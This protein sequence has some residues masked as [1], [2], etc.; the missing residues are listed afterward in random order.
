[1]M[2]FMKHNAGDND[3][4]Q[5]MNRLSEYGIHAE[6]YPTSPFKTIFFRD[7]GKQIPSLTAVPGVE[8]IVHTE[9]RYRLTSR[10]SKKTDTVITVGD[11][12]IGGGN[13]CV[14]AGPCAVE[15]EQL[16]LEISKLLISEGFAIMRGGAFKPRTSPYS[17][18]GLGYDGLDILES[19]KKE[20]GILVVTEAIDVESVDRVE[21]VADIIQVGSRNM[22]NFSLLKH[23]GT[24]SRPVLLKRGM[25]STIEEL[26][27][28]AEYIYSGGNSEIIL[29]ERGIRTF[30]TTTRNTLDLT[31]I[32]AIK[33]LSHLP[34]MVDPS[35]AT[36]RRNFIE[37]ISKAI[38]AA[39]ADGMLLEVHPN[40]EF[41]LSD[42][43]QSINIEEFISL[44]EKLKKLAGFL[45]IKI[46]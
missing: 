8:R 32:P 7:E 40:P 6:V 26:L 44:M 11:R 20:T 14:M 17:F 13:F 28:A 42:G 12:K 16:S 15:S 39:G 33:E 25:S 31:A 2:I 5:V 10:A 3:I 37:P 34:V 4:Q 41:A 38:M 30:E 46:N 1:M 27:L 21:R 19:V 22:Q 18:Q 35:H 23:L 45:G 9:P 36:G 24:V 43:G 29:C